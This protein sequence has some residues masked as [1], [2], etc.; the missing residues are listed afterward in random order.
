[1]PIGKKQS[2]DSTLYALIAFVFLFI[3]AITAAI[4][5]YL[6]FENQRGK[7]ENEQRKREEVA[8][9]DELD[10]IG[11][12][13]GTEQAE[14]SRLQEMTDY[15]NQT[16]S[17]IVP[18]VPDPNSAEVKIDEVTKKVRNEMAE[19]SR[20][21]PELADVD[22][23]TSLLQ[24]TKKMSTALKNTRDAEA[25]IK[26]QLAILQGR[27]DDYQDEGQ[28]MEK[29]LMEE[30]EKFQQQYE[31]AR[32][33]YD[34]LKALLEK[35]SDE[36]V[37]DLLGKLEQ[38]RNNREEMNKQL[39]RTQAELRM[40]DGRIQ[41]ILKESV[42]PLK[43]P[44]GADVK[45]FEP[46]GSVIMIDDQSKIVHIDL[47][48]DDRIYR[49]LT[50]S[51]Y[52]KDQPIPK[53]GKGKAEIEIFN[54]GDEVSQARIIRV[55]PKNAIVTGDIIA[56]LIWDAKRVNT[57]VI[58]GDFDLNGDGVVDADA[59]ERLG[60]L[61]K[62]WG[63]KVE[64]AVTV[65]TDFVVLGTQPVILPKPTLEETSIYPNAME[66]YEKAIERQA[67]Y[68]R[69]QE[70]AQSLSIP[71]LNLERFLYF[72]GYEATAGKPGAF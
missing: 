32:S 46:D 11:S 27:F 38:E 66:K 63:G 12:I 31:K 8:T 16:I 64:D 35:K 72:I 43:P 13:V 20:Q 36:Q 25:A 2:G 60:G 65:N 5:F 53:T 39:L 51:V 23:N 70:Q 59:I 22:P 18:G 41:Q 40:A 24:I 67:G 68:T 58:A 44:P 10:R 61:V 1:M 42:W 15:L 62:K 26:E 9:S 29:I 33:G 54:I 14:K 69:I 3:A 17:L 49:G 56:N 45:A 47:G 34:E 48:K 19:I 7:A 52:D 21:N 28:K 4:I 55:E 57:F 30:K 6:Q 71:T 37:K 50:F